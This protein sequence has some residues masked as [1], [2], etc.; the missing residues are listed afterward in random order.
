[1]LQPM[2]S[3]AAPT[4]A[5]AA[6]V[7]SRVEARIAELGLRLPL[8]LKPPGGSYAPYRTVA[9]APGRR[10]VHLAGS[11]PFVDGQYAFVGKVGADFSVAEGQEAARLCVLGM[12]GH[13]K[14]ACGGDLDKVTACLKLG[15]FVN[16]PPDFVD[17][18]VVGNG[19]SELVVA[20]FGEAVG[21]H[22]RAAVGVA[23]LPRGVAVEIDG[24]FEVRE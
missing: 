17:H 16:C 13:L 6:E 15:V 23:S 11:V 12:L 20:A 7:P 9:S 10:I 4:G 18:P 1:M 21:A 22:A 14:H 2:S 8:D 19:G 3:V 5:V 24:V